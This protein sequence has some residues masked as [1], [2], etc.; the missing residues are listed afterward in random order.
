MAKTQ[1]KN[2]VFKPGLGATGNLYPNAYSLINAN[3]SFIQ[4]EM[5]AYIADKVAAAAQYTP[6]GATYA[7]TTG[8]L[9][10]TIGTHNFNVGD[11]IIIANGG[12][13][14]T[15]NSG[16]AVPFFEKALIITE[17]VANS[18]VTV[19]AGI[20]TDTTTHSWVSSV[21]DA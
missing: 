3:K 7:P 11:A 15:N 13:T 21:T 20:S 9:V 8:V 18:S 2:Y 5:S 19:N 16:G 1:I 10:L 6:T 14:F 17:V 4:K 12:I